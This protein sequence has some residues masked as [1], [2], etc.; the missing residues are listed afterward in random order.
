MKTIV[1]WFGVIAFV[2]I[3]GLSFA[4]CKKDSL[5]GTTWK[6]VYEGE[7]FVLTFKNPNLTLTSKWET[8]TG[9]YTVSGSTITI[10]SVD[11]DI[12]TGTLSG[13]TLS[14]DDSGLKFTKQ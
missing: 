2:T 1:K 14:F 8:I 9:T 4:A 13:N 10:I 3:I 7:N 5:D 11:G 12:E 6:A